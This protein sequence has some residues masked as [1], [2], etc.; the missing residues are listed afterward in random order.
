M[1]TYA[2][3]TGNQIFGYGPDWI[4]L[5]IGSKKRVHTGSFLSEWELGN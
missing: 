5:S 4:P 3:Q 2:Y 1:H